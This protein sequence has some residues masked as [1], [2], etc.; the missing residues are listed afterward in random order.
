MLYACMKKAY[1]CTGG[2][3]ADQTLK[4]LLNKAEM[5]TK[6]KINEEKSK[7]ASK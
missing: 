4:K 2:A 7:K 6:M 1:G 3:D 5:E